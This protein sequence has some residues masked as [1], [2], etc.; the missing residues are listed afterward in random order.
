[1][2]IVLKGPTTGLVVGEPL[3]PRTEAMKARPNK[4]AAGRS[5]RDMEAPG[6]REG[7]WGAPCRRVRRSK[8]VMASGTSACIGTLSILAQARGPG[9][10][11]PAPSEAGAPC[12]R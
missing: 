12:R 7:P 11:L 6:G 3:Q 10:A 4:S 1:M 5:M 9:K 2:V 8:M